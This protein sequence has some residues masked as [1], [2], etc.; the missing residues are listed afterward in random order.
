[1]RFINEFNINCGE[2]KETEI[3]SEACECMFTEPQTEEIVDMSM[4]TQSL[5]NIIL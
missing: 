1:M 4:L 3:P 5:T 2:K